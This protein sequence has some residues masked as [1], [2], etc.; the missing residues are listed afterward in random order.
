MEQ[1][2]FEEPMTCPK[3]QQPMKHRFRQQGGVV[4]HEHWS[5]ERC[6][7]RVVVTDEQPEPTLKTTRPVTFLRG[8]FRS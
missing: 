7:K 2:M 4:T 3:C 1:I 5:C 8:L 6:H